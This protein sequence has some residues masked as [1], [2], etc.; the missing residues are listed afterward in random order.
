VLGYSGQF[1][2]SGH[3]YYTM[4]VMVGACHDIK[5]AYHD[6]QTL[7]KLRFHAMVGAYSYH[8]MHLP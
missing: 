4:Y 2:N 5:D 7:Y 1:V 8:D 3:I 6:I